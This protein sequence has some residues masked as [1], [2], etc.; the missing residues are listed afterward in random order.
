MKGGKLFCT[1]YPCHNCARHIIAAGVAEVYYIE[2][3][4]KSLSTFLHSDALTESESDEEK[5]KVKI[6]MFDGVSPNRYLD[7]FG[8]HNKRKTNGIHSPLTSDQLKK[9][10]PTTRMSLNDIPALEAKI[11]ERLASKKITLGSN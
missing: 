6:L 11:L 7:F 10:T 3:Y 8:I 9:C 5:T 1:T 2:P 4:E